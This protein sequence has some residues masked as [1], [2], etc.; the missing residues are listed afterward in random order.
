MRKYLEEV[1][2]RP[3][4]SVKPQPESLGI[5]GRN[6]SVISDVKSIKL[7]RHV[8]LSRMSFIQI[9]ESILWGIQPLNFPGKGIL[10]RCCLFTGFLQHCVFLPT[11]NISCLLALGRAQEVLVAFHCLQPLLATSKSCSNLR[12]FRLSQSA[13]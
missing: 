13:I 11:Y 6:L 1:V 12:L 3:S 8:A 5:K 9:L 10:H 4:V 2:C 7:F